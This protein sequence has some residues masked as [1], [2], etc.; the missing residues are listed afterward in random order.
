MKPKPVIHE[1]QRELFRIELEQLVDAEHPLV[2]L[3]RQIDWAGFDE[4][5]GATYAAAT[6]APGRSTRLM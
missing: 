5:L 6:G 1:A 3:G 2:K 4:R